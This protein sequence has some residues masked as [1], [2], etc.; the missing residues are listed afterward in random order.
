MENYLFTPV[1]LIHDSHK[2]FLGLFFEMFRNLYEMYSWSVN[3]MKI[4]YKI[5]IVFGLIIPRD[6]NQLIYDYFI[7]YCYTF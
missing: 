4:Q 7:V 3:L 1:I 5:M 2:W 6:R